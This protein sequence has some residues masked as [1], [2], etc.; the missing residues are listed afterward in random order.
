[1]L[2][3]LSSRKESSSV[4]VEGVSYYPVRGVIGGG[5]ADRF[6]V[7]EELVSSSYSAALGVNDP[8]CQVFGSAIGD[9]GRAEGVRDLRR[10]WGTQV[11]VVIHGIRG[12][13]G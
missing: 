5:V 2:I 7:V 11:P 6:D 13:C 8:L 4:V 10:Y 12:E 3:T 1:M 9:D